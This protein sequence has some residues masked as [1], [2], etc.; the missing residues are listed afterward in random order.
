MLPLP[1]SRTFPLLLSCLFTATFLGGS[2]VVAQSELGRKV[3]FNFEV[4]PILAGSCY[5]CHGPD[6]KQRKGDLR[7]DLR[8]AALEQGAIVPGN[9]G[10]SPLVERIFTTD[11]EDVMPPT[12]SHR[13]LTEEQKEVLKRWIAQ[14]AEYEKHWAF[15]PPAKVPVPSIAKDAGTFPLKSPIDNFVLES[16][17]QKGLAPAAPTRKERWL[18]R[19]TFDL[20]GLPPTLTEIEVYLADTAPTAKE[21]VVERL[22][23]SRHYGERLATDWLDAAR[24]ADS[25][26][27]HEDAESAVWP[28]RDWVIQAFNDNLPYDKF[29][30]IQTA[31]DLLSPTPSQPD[32]IATAFNRLVQQSN[33]AGSNEEEFRQEHVAD[34]IKTNATAILG[35]TL[36]CARCHDHKYDPLTQREYYQMAAFFNNV[37]ELGLFSRTTAATP[38]PTLHLLS[39]ELDG[40]NRELLLQI[41][42]AEKEWNELQEKSR[43]RYTAWAN[44]NANP[45]PAT[46]LAHYEFESVGEKKRGQ[47]KQFTDALHPGKNVGVARQSIEPMNGVNGLAL[48]FED[49]NGAAFPDVGQF[50]RG[51]TFSFAL[52]IRPEEK[53]ERAVVIHRSRGGLDAASR[54]YELMLNDLHPEFALSHFAPGNSIRVRAKG[55]IAL[56][57]WSH[58]VATYDGSSRAEGIHL[59]INGEPT[60]VEVLS[61]HL[62]RDILYR[63]EWGDYDAVKLQDNLGEQVALTIGYRKN[64]RV[65][66]NASFDDF[67]VFDK[68]LTPAEAEY[69]TTLVPKKEE[70]RGVWAG[71]WYGLTHPF[72]QRAPE[73]SPEP[74][75]ETWLRDI[76]PQGT[77]LLKKLHELRTAQDNLANDAKE[78]MVMQEMTPRRRTHVLARGQFDQPGAEVFPETP[79]SVLPMTTDMPRNRLGL[80]QWYV[81]R[82]NPLT[83]RVAVNRVWQIF[84]GRGIVGTTEDFGIQGEL[85]THPALL[86]WL[87]TDFR[88]HGW[89]MKRLCRMIALSSTYGQSSLP[90]DPRLL[91]DDPENRLLARGPRHRLSAEMIRDNALAA[92]GLLVPLV[93]GPSVRPYA[94]DNLY[95]DAGIQNHYHQDKGDALWRRSLYTFWKRTMPPP[96]L[97]VFDAPSREYCRVRRE[98]T[99]TPMQSLAMMNAP[100]F[101]EAARVLAEQLVKSHPQ[102]APKR[103]AEAFRLTTSRPATEAETAVL[104]QLFEAERAHFT[105]LPEDAEKVRGENGEHPADTALPAVEVAATTMVVRTLLSSDEASVKQ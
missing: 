9:P 90:A 68:A 84:F 87:A 23:G 94:P 7:L 52:W 104:M 2:R 49:D 67:K 50:R 46:P 17:E 29:L 21:T 85:P 54:G 12:D 96:T 39:P 100:E 36:E 42:Q 72:V 37:N 69:L 74:W 40:R 86:D 95:E 83:A 73:P 4:Q 45:D 70:K 24:Y 19:V 61:N 33:E 63:P 62:Y 93:G 89:D 20:T 80:A 75:Y 82:Q 99:S 102:D 71:I 10:K 98:N 30:V 18:R 14:G 59:Y 16:L 79:A 57:E 6:A 44:S 48:R 3:S 22:L 88:D 66:K 35:L 105:G 76:D 27:R 64:D 43:D 13:T 92:S 56:K 53:Q 65:I 38:A 31:G 60:E 91:K 5:Q 81:D 8:E 78:L 58:V 34:R 47:R 25:Y 55:T 41:Q 51:D 32:L 26:G 103:I 11:V 15:I 1:S 28:Y 101:I 97:A 77:A